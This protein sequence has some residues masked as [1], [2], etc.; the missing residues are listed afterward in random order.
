MKI[1][2]GKTS[3]GKSTIQNI[4]TNDYNYDKSWEREEIIDI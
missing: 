3:S 2:L 1:L 4:L